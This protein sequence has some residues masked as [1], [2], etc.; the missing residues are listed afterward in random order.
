MPSFPN[1][2]S[3]GIQNFPF[4]YRRLPFPLRFDLQMLTNCFCKR[5]FHNPT[6]ANSHILYIPFPSDEAMRPESVFLLP[7]S[8]HR[9]FQRNVPYI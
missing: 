4:A 6:E 5:R 1:N 8:I 9:S 2:G 3:A 7:W